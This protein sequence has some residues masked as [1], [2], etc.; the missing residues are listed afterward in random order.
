MA[1]TIISRH[2]SIEAIEWHI[3]RAKDEIESYKKHVEKL[4]NLLAEKQLEQ[5]KKIS[6]AHGQGVADE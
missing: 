2:W 6:A 1:I 5:Q 3:R 4:E